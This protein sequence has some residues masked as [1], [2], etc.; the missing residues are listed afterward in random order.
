MKF[1]KILILPLLLLLFVA[2]EDEKEEASNAANCATVL[3]EMLSAAETFNAAMESS[4]ATRSQCEEYVTKA[5]AYANC[6][7]AGQEKT[8]I[9]D[10]VSEV[11]SLCPIFPN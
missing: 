6:L 7:P 4:T 8:E 9:L 10:S 3:A 5:K 1:S 2:C 11:E